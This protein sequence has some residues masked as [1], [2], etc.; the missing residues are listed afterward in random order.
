MTLEDDLKEARQRLRDFAATATA[1]EGW[2]HHCGDFSADDE[3][4]ALTRLR[5]EVESMRRSSGAAARD[6][7]NALRRA[8]AAEAEAAELRAIVDGVRTAC[9]LVPLSRILNAPKAVTE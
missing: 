4:P 3:A 8:E 6:L 7:S 2:C 1:E 5:A 9:G